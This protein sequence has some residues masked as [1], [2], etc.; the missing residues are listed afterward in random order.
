MQ[1]LEGHKALSRHRP[2]YTNQSRNIKTKGKQSFEDTRDIT[3][4]QTQNHIRNIS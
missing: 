4:L 2:E 1:N 3:L